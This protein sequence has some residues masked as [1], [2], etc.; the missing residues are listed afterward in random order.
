MSRGPM[1]SHSSGFRSMPAEAPDR[2][3]W[4]CD[5]AAAEWDRVVPILLQAELLARV[6]QSS[7][8]AYCQ[9]CA[10]LISCTRTVESEG[11]FVRE[12]VQNSKGEVLGEKIKAHPALAGQRD[13][14]GRVR[15]YLAEFGL[16]PAARVRL[17]LMKEGGQDALTALLSG[18]N[19]ATQADET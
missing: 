1:P 13:A 17:K 9:A 11:R 19:A 2:P 7:L 10:E 5:E 4:L 16:S 12:P 15:S 14:L 18:E 6:D 3:D 8:A